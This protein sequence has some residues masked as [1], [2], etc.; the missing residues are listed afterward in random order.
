MPTHYDSRY[1]TG[2]TM[3]LAQ[4]QTAAETAETKVR[5]WADKTYSNYDWFLRVNKSTSFVKMWS[6]ITSKGWQKP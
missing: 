5:A 6:F 2:E 4:R 1:R 3:N